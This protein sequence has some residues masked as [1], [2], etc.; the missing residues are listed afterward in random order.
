MSDITKDVTEKIT[1]NYNGEDIELPRLSVR[2][3][4]RLLSGDQRK[5]R[6][7]LKEDLKDAGASP[8]D[9]VS[10]LADFDHRIVDEQTW[11]DF[12]NDAR[13]EYYIYLAS[14]TKNGRSNE[15]ADKIIGEITTKIE[16]RSQIAPL[17]GLQLVS[18]PVGEDQTG[19][20]PENPQIPPAYGK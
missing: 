3:R 8:E 6:D 15:E 16:N 1:V 12:V 20:N 19:E 14:L 9:I 17:C 4:S 11:I 10:T 2:D 18:R 13:N 5:K 7:Q